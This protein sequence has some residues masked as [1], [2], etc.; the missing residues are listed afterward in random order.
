[1][2]ATIHKVSE[3][4]RAPL[5]CFATEL[6]QAFQLLDDLI[7]S[8]GPVAAERPE[9][10]GKTTLL[11]LLGHEKARDRLG[12]HLDNAVAALPSGSHLARFVRSIFAGSLAERAP[13]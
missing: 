13:A 1:M 6:G 8:N 3:A 7:D 9:D 2:A 12:D 10:E 4:A 5:R 11:S